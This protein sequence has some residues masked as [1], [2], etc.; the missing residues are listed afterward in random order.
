MNLKLKALAILFILIL[1]LTISTV[2]GRKVKSNSL[3]SHFSKSQTKFASAQDVLDK[4]NQY[5]DYFTN[6]SCAK[7]YYKLL[8]YYQWI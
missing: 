7:T 4:I 3:K 5:I 6:T 8:E 2:E 1:Y